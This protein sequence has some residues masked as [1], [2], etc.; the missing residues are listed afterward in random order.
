MTYDQAMESHVQER[1]AHATER[2]TRSD[3]PYLLDLINVLAPHPKGLRRWSV[4]RAIRTARESTGRPVPQKFEDEVERAFRR[5]CAATEA[6][7]TNARDSE[8]ALFYKP[9][10]KAGEVWAVYSERAEAWLK[11]ESA[12][13]D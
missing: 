1:D 3:R 10:G 8:A 12:H 4:M 2:K 9:E 13:A 5:S 7:K 11:S 6:F